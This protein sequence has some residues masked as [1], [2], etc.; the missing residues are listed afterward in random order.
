MSRISCI[1][2][3]RV[4]A[5]KQAEVRPTHIVANLSDDDG[6]LRFTGTNRGLTNSDAFRPLATELER[7][8]DTVRLLRCLLLKLDGRLRVE[9]LPRDREHGDID[10]I[11]SSRGSD[12][13]VGGDGAVE[14]SLKCQRAGRWRLSHHG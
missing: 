6:D 14:R 8:R 1:S 2:E 9:A 7:H 10:R 5:N 12:R 3:S 11:S 4:S 13:R